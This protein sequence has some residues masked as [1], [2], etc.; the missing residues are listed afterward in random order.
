MH[1]LWLLP[2]LFL[3]VSLSSI[4]KWSSYTMLAPEM[5]LPF[6]A[7]EL[8]GMDLEMI[9][10]WVKGQD[11]QT[12]AHIAASLNGVLGQKLSEYSHVTLIRY[13]QVLR[14]ACRVLPDSELF[15]LLTAL[16][17]EGSVKWP[18][19]LKESLFLSME[20][21]ISSELSVTPSD[22][23][24]L[25]ERE[26]K[27][28][29]VNLYRVVPALVMGK[30]LITLPPVKRVNYMR[31]MSLL[32]LPL[33]AILQVYGTFEDGVTQK[34][35]KAH[36]VT[37]HQWMESLGFDISSL[38]K[39]A[40]LTFEMGNKFNILQTP[41]VTLLNNLIFTL[42]FALPLEL[43][44]TSTPTERRRRLHVIKSHLQ[45]KR[46][47]INNLLNLLKFDPAEL[48]YGL[49]CKEHDLRNDQISLTKAQQQNIL[50]YTEY[51]RLM[52][53]LSGDVA[54][55]REEGKKLH[56][57]M[58]KKARELNNSF[59]VYSCSVK[60]MPVPS[61]NIPDYF[62]ALVLFLLQSSHDLGSHRESH[63]T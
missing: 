32:D 23:S 40:Y 57:D 42:E 43:L 8:N 46:E 24:G 7:K 59:K 52:S 31:E 28:V 62:S 6:I 36:S 13:K 26:R 11:E 51:I 61:V 21:Q 37:K 19:D 38:T 18:V 1:F 34:L 35:L 3:Q 58:K 55:W 33:T 53:I 10:V 44:R 39:L 41:S 49:E 50:L 48:R 60:K 29:Y 17:P 15:S 20:K 25:T 5:R 27:L 16:S 45:S 4:S 56:Q 14:L 30:F 12:R 63:L 47:E 2:L 9:D 22:I 54:K